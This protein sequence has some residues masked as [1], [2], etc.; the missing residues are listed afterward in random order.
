MCIMILIY[1]F[2]IFG[3][4]APM[5]KSWGFTTVRVALVPC[6]EFVQKKLATLGKVSSLPVVQPFAYAVYIVNVQKK[7][8]FFTRF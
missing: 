8:P 3:D 1:R 5:T 2:I 6:K 4:G 7:E